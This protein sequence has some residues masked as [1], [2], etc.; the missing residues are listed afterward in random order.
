MLWFPLNGFYKQLQTCL[1]SPLLDLLMPHSSLLLS[2]CLLLQVSVAL[3]QGQNTLFIGV[4]ILED[5]FHYLRYHCVFSLFIHLL[6]QCSIK[7]T[8]SRLFPASGG[9]FVILWEEGV[10]VRVK[11][12]TSCLAVAEV[13]YTRCESL[14]VICECWLCLP[15]HYHWAACQNWPVWYFVLYCCSWMLG[16]DGLLY[17]SMSFMHTRAG[18][19]RYQFESY[20]LL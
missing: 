8:W 14:E 17:Y 5:I 7:V 16:Y 13:T 20:F 12:C 19:A 4:G 15:L 1:S 6:Q 2:H 3:K 18:K 10:L 11:R 9:N